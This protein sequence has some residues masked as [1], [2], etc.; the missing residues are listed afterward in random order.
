MIFVDL[1]NEKECWL[2]CRLYWSEKEDIELQRIGA[3]PPEDAYQKW[4]DG[5]HD[6]GPPP[7]NMTPADEWHA[8]E[9]DCEAQRKRLGI[10]A[11]FYYELEV[12]EGLQGIVESLLDWSST[13]DLPTWAR[14]GLEHG[15]APFQPFLLRL[16]RPLYTRDSEGEYD[17][18]YDF[19]VMRVWPLDPDS[20]L[21]RWERYF[22]SIGFA[23]QL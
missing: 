6:F 10:P 22:K 23:T 11:W 3:S 2:W 4:L 19:G 14:F 15:I 21:K 8:H 1:L 9:D 18:E 5:H 17:V 12:G 7:M 13:D 16:P 20:A